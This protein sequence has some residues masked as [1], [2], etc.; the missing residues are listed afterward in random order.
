M[1]H[2]WAS[3]SRIRCQ[4]LAAPAGSFVGGVLLGGVPVGGA[5]I[6]SSSL[7]GAPRESQEGACDSSVMLEG[8]AGGAAGGAA[9]QRRSV[10]ASWAV[11]TPCAWAVAAPPPYPHVEWTC[12]GRVAVGAAGSG[13]TEGGAGVAAA[14]VA[15]APPQYLR[16]RGVKWQSVRMAVGVNG[17]RWVTTACWKSATAH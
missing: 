4:T 5:L 17:S 15:A 9:G 16:L 6:V 12:A 14:A 3:C 2:R 8:T 11:F 7:S 13:T 10:G 1:A